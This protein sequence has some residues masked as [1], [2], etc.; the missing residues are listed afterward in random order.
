MALRR[1]GLSDLCCFTSGGDG[2]E[3]SEQGP[4]NLT[5]RNTPRL[6]YFHFYLPVQFFH[7]ATLSK[8]SYTERCLRFFPH[9]PQTT[10]NQPTQIHTPG[11]LGWSYTNYTQCAV[12]L[13]VGSVFAVPLFRLVYTAT[14]PENVRTICRYKI[15]FTLC[16]TAD[17]IAIYLGFEVFIAV[18]AKVLASSLPYL[19]KGPADGGD[20]QAK[21][22]ETGTETNGAPKYSARSLA[23]SYALHRFIDPSPT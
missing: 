6:F 17:Q 16:Y 2:G 7:Q 21:E 23:L 1:A 14:W 3:T 12:H 9:R 19:T 15:V 20:P 10:P 11:L 8:C 5:G 13:M 18:V 22:T 4:E